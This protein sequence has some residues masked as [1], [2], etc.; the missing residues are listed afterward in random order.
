MEKSAKPNRR[1]VSGERIVTMALTTFE[2]NHT[3]ADALRAF[4]AK[5]LARKAGTSPRTAENWC[6]GRAAPTWKHAVA[7]LND[8]ELCARLLEAAGRSD[9]A[10]AQETIVAL[11]TALGMVEGTK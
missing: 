6:A 2:A 3:L 1:T 10:H 5:V 8:D 9:L 4:G 7:M 11:R